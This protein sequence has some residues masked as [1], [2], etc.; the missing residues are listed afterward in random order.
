[1]DVIDVE[2]QYIPVKG[3]WNALQNQ[4]CTQLQ[5]YVKQSQFLCLK[6]KK[7]AT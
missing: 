5:N 2:W 3:L 1:M 7:E 4:R 6:I